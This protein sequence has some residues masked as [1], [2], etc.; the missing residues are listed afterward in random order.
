[1]DGIIELADYPEFDTRVAFLEEVPIPPPDQPPLV[2]LS[3]SHSDG[4]MYTDKVQVSGDVNDDVGAIMVEF[5]ID[6]G[7]WVL[8]ELEGTAWTLDVPT[9]NLDEGEHTL[10]V[11]AY[12]GIQ[13]SAIASTTFSF[14]RSDEEPGFGAMIAVIAMMTVLVTTRSRRRR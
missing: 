13:Y 9:Q 3:G 4:M 6:N 12:D 8:S 11:R 14:E 2:A 10:E 1:M 7:S 5:R